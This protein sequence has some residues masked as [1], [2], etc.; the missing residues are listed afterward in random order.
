MSWFLARHL[1]HLDE[2]DYEEESEASCRIAIDIILIQCR[3]YIKRKYFTAKA[4]PPFLT[5]PSTPTKNAFDL[6]AA[7]PRKPVKFYPEST[8]SVL[9]PDRFA[10]DKK[11]LV[12]GRADWA[13]GY[14]SKDEDGALLAALEAKKKSEFGSGQSQLIAY[15]AIIRENRRKAGRTNKITQGFYSDGDCFAFICIDN[16]GCI[17]TSPIWDVRANGGL[18][19]VYSFIIAMLENAL[20]SSPTVTPTKPS[21]QQDKEIKDYEVWPM[22][23]NRV[24][25]SLKISDGRSDDDMDSD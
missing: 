8:I 12:T 11:F 13:F 18:N 4:E 10:P 17:L 3:R 1:A 7:T 9:V 15:L 2:A 21:K 24:E 20:K 23:L 19:M 14:S 22:I 5:A 25:K 6:P 16:D